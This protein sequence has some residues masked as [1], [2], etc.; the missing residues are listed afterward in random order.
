MTHMSRTAVGTPATRTGPGWGVQCPPGLS[1]CG[2]AAHPQGAEPILGQGSAG[3]VLGP[4]LRGS[5]S[6]VNLT[7]W[8]RQTAC[9]PCTLLHPQPGAA[10][11]AGT[12]QPGQV[13]FGK[14]STVLSFAKSHLFSYWKSSYRGSHIGWFTPQMATI[15]VTAARCSLWVSPLGWVQGSEPLGCPHCL[16][17]RAFGRG[18][19]WDTPT[20][21]GDADPAVPL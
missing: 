9:Q 18:P 11:V 2:G 10:G 13:L 20:G 6:C 8:S 16:P 15:A 5:A 1:D 19:V 3:F 4:S 21:T 12:Q 17:P 14:P 7:L